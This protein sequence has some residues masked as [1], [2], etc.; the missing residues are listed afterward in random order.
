MLY[1]VMNNLHNIFI[2]LSCNVINYS[3]EP[4]K[5]SEFFLENWEITKTTQI[6][7][8]MNEMNWNEMNWINWWNWATW[9]KFHMT[10]SFKMAIQFNSFL[11]VG[12][13]FTF[14]PFLHF[15]K[16]LL[17]EILLLLNILTINTLLNTFTIYILLNTFIINILLNSSTCNDYMELNFQLWIL[18]SLER[19]YVYFRLLMT[20]LGNSLSTRIY[21]WGHS[22]K[23]FSLEKIHAD[24]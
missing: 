15:L 5:C 9:S 1:V 7:N 18:L 14:F 16:S 23:T 13:T 10:F 22:I 20:L 4:N 24:F 19:N 17:L 8:W 2:L 12:F 21:R 11:H 6:V 3:I